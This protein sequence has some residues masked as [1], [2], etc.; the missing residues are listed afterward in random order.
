MKQRSCSIYL[1]ILCLFF[2]AVGTYLFSRS[3]NSPSENRSINYRR[4]LLR[5]P[6][7]LGLCRKAAKSLQAQRDREAAVVEHA[8]AANERRREEALQQRQKQREEREQRQAEERREKAVLDAAEASLQERRNAKHLRKFMSQARRNDI[9]KL[10]G[11]M[12]KQMKREFGDWDFRV[13]M[14]DIAEEKKAAI[15]RKRQRAELR[16]ERLRIESKVQELY[17]KPPEMLRGG[18]GEKEDGR[19]W[20]R[21]QT[22]SI[23]ALSLRPIE[24]RSISTPLRHPKWRGASDTEKLLH[25]RG[26]RRQAVTEAQRDVLRAHLRE[27]SAAKGAL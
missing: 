25:T 3:K 16:R 4:R 14:K 5:C 23:E 6:E 19:K 21:A 20:N 24:P 1:S 17:D 15:D 7:L 9:D 11:A 27:I 8:R 10:H 26:N 22:E 18:R 2:I 12:N 13:K